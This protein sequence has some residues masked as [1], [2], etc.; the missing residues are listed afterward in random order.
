MGIIAFIDN[1]ALND[2]LFD[3]SVLG[4]VFFLLFLVNI[5]QRYRFVF[6]NNFFPN[7]DFFNGFTLSELPHN[8]FLCIW[9][10]NRVGTVFHGNPLRSQEVDKRSL[11]DIQLSGQSVQ[12]YLLFIRHIVPFRFLGKF[13]VKIVIIY[14]IIKSSPIQRAGKIIRTRHAEYP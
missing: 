6:R 9:L 4:G 2:H 13:N 12:S 5:A 14:M 7:I 3:K 10:D 11:P 1:I 8:H